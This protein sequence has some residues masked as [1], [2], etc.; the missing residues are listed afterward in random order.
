[1][2]PLCSLRAQGDSAKVN[3]VLGRRIKEEADAIGEMGVG[4]IIPA[5]R[6]HRLLHKLVGLEPTS[7]S[8]AAVP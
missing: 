8:A 3:Q 7:A 4:E 1:M 2:L 6:R 5:L